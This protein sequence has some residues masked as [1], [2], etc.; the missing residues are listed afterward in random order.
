MTAP[1][2]LTEAL[3]PLHCTDTSDLRPSHHAACRLLCPIHQPRG[4]V[5]SG[6]QLIPHFTH[7]LHRRIPC[8]S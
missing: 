4:L 1:Q 5:G 8:E 7:I 2:A 6:R 3:Y